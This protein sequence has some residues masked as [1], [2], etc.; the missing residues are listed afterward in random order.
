MWAGGEWRPASGAAVSALDRGYLYGDGVFET[1][2]SRAG[3]FFRLDAHLS[4]M[5]RGL[6]VLGIS[7]T[8]DEAF[9]RSRAGEAC[10]LLGSGDVVF[11]L[12]VSRG[13]GW[14]GPAG[15]GEPGVTLLAAL[16]DPGPEEDRG[17]AVCLSQVRRDEDSP[18]SSLK[19]CCWLPSVLALREAER[20]GCQE[21]VMLC[22]AGYVSECAAGNLFWVRDGTLFTPSLACGGLPGITRAAVLDAAVREGIPC[23]EGEFSPRALGEAESAFVTGSVRGVRMLG[24]FEGAVLRP[25]DASGVIPRL[26]RRFERMLKEES[27]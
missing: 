6:D 27:R 10:R 12:T 18:L 7:L 21:A 11:R 25:G 24:A 5:R 20:R 19:T 15:D 22:R 17:L 16:P 1:F 9:V 13:P 2:R 14:R 23:V 26:L 8:V 3:R 4:R